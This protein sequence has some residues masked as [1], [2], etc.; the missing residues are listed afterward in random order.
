MAQTAYNAK[1]LQLAWLKT[2]DLATALAI[3]INEGDLITDAMITA[4]IGSITWQQFAVNSDITDHTFIVEP[5]MQ[6]QFGEFTRDDIPVK[7][8][9]KPEGV[10]SRIHDSSMST[11]HLDLFQN[12]FGDKV[13]NSENNDS[14]DGDINHSVTV[15]MLG[16]G[17][18]S[19]DEGKFVKVGNQASI[20]TNVTGSVL[21]FASKISAKDGDVIEVLD[22]F[23]TDVITDES[24]I[25]FVRTA[26]GARLVSHVRFGIDFETP[27]GDLLMLKFKYQGDVAL[28]STLTW[29]T[30]GTVTK[31][32]YSKDMTT[33]HFKGVSA[34][35]AENRCVGAFVFKMEREMNRLPCQGTESLNGNGGTFREKYST[36]DIQITAYATIL[37]TEYEAKTDIQL[38]AQKLDFAIY[39]PAAL[40]ASENVN[41]VNDNVENVVYTIAANTDQ[42]KKMMFIL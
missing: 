13:V 3:T 34:G 17:L 37:N 6:E 12:G 16:I 2:S 15:T 24:F 1:V 42:D 14:V 31:E 22:H 9:E 21:T 20:L 11:T 35:S 18:D 4:A 38:L 33:T 10:L 26:R 32:A 8:F 23:D 29:G 39:A 28:E 25:L 36:A 27:Y 19:S 40:I 5:L 30:I 7:G 41:N